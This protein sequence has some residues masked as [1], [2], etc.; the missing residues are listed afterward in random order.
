VNLV[1][2]RGNVIGGLSSW[3]LAW[4]MAQI[5]RLGGAVRVRRGDWPVSTRTNVLCSA[6]RTVWLGHVGGS[7]LLKAIK[8]LTETVLL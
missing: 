8:H 5:Q 3:G 6:R 4:L 7:T 2:A 1:I